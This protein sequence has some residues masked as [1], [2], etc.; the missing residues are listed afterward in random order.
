MPSPAPSPRV[1][2]RGVGDVDLTDL[3]IIRRYSLA[4][5]QDS[6]SRADLLAVLRSDLDRLEHASA[7]ARSASPTSRPS[8]QAVTKTPAKRA[9]AKR[10]AGG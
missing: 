9:S 4:V 8:P 2:G 5:R 10:T 6:A 7:P 3:E 1:P